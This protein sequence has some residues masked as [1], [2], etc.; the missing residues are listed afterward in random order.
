MR[1][2]KLN[3]KNLILFIPIFLAIIYVVYNLGVEVGHWV[4]IYY[5]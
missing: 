5:K 3:R 1:K 4:A 2:A